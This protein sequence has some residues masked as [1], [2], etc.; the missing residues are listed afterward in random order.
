M[1][2]VQNATLAGGVAIGTSCNM[3]VYPGGAL[4][5]GMVAGTL[6]TFGFA[7]IQGFLGEYNNN[8]WKC[9]AIVYHLH[10]ALH[11][12]YSLDWGFM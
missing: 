6:S 12:R 7:K 8:F 2:H 10:E 5:I 11:K 9:S 4:A 3:M 1:A